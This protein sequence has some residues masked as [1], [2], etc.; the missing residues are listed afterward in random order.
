M[1]RLSAT[2]VG[3]NVSLKIGAARAIAPKIL[4]ICV[5]VLRIC[6]LWISWCRNWMRIGLDRIVLWEWIHC[7]T[8]V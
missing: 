8:I 4:R 3:M 6:K 1:L 5:I 2:A 7:P